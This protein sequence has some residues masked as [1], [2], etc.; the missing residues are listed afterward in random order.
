MFLCKIRT[1]PTSY[2][3]FCVMMALTPLVNAN[4][5]IAED[6]WRFTP[7]IYLWGAGING[8]TKTGTDIEVGF[9]ELLDNL[10]LGVMGAFEVRKSKWFMV[11]DLIYLDVSADKSGNLSAPA[12]PRGQ[13]KLDADINANIDLQGWIINLKGGAQYLAE[14]SFNCRCFC[15]CSLP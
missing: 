12:G 11:V 4:E 10:N 5:P 1:I 8:T 15:R 2:F 9:D 7:A 13:A 14:R 6:S 3:L